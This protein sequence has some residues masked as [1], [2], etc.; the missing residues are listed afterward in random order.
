MSRRDAAKPNG[1]S[2]QVAHD[3]DAPRPLII[4][5][6]RG[7]VTFT[8]R[9]GGAF[10]SRKGSGGV[11]TAVS[12]VARERQ[13]V[14]IAAAMTDG[15]RQRA[16]VAR[17]NDEQLIEYGDPAEFRLRFVVPTPEAYHQYYNVISN[18]LLWFLQHY[19]WDTPRSPDITHE[20]WDAWRNG[21]V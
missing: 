3:P 15:D 20:I 5:S 18:P 8:R 10:D 16:A 11:V 17:E 9:P 13:P 7:P 1:P 6:N 19:L 21:Y 12:A 14:W 2:G 4:A